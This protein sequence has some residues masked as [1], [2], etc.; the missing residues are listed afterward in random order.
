MRA[1]EGEILAAHDGRREGADA[2]RTEG[3]ARDRLETGDG[4][5]VVDGDGVDAVEVGAHRAAMGCGH[6]FGHFLHAALEH[7]A[8]VLAQRAVGALDGGAIWDDVERAARLHDGDADDGRIERI[9][10]A[11][12]HRL[13]GGD[14]GGGADDRVRAAVWP[15]G[16]RTATVDMDLEAVARGHHGAAAR[17]DG[18]EGEFGPAVERVDLL[19]LRADAAAVERAFLDHALAAGAAFFG[20]LEDERHRPRERVACRQA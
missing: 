20:G 1:V 8:R 19:H 6:A 3:V 11:C 7:G 15:R 12:H 4:A 17:G 16:V 2:F 5:I 10:V 9:D 13:Q 14:D 18:T